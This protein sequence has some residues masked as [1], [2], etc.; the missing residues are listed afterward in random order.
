MTDIAAQPF[1]VLIAVDWGTTSCR[2]ALL[3]NT[4]DVLA[5][6]L[7]G[8][9]ILAIA[10]RAFGPALTTLI[11]SWRGAAAAVPIIL[12]GMIGS[13]QGWVEAPYVRCPAG[14]AEVAAKLVRIEATEF[15]SVYI[16]PGLE[17][18]NGVGVPDVMRGEETQI[19]GALLQARATDGL[20]VLPGTHSKWAIVEAA[21]ITGF[22]TFMT[23]EVFAALKEHTIL[24]RLMKTASA[25][26]DGT[27]SAFAAGVR[28]GSA[29]GEPGALLHRIFAARTLGL[30]DQIAPDGLPE[31]LSGLLIGA[32][33]AEVSKGV[34]EP[35]TIIGNDQL[36]ERYRAAGAT[37]GLSCSVAPSNCATVGLLQI[38]RAAGVLPKK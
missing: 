20:F 5:S 9:G 22:R 38:A 23:G 24:G 2:A 33:I 11:E 18:R 29:E 16:V 32:E 8:P 26:T 35:V 37:L 6:N 36:A 15:G 4:G 14:L 31:Y 28:A 25:P 7:V 19:F 27:R 10:D 13:R 17:T 34:Q 21:R 30:F 1:P 12:S 3:A